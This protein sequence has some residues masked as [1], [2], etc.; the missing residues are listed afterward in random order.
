MRQ[1]KTWLIHSATRY[2][3]RCV[4]FLTGLCVLVIEVVA[5]RI[6]SPHFGNTIYSV[7]SVISVILTALALGYSYGGRL[8]D[9]HPS[10]GL[11]YRVILSSGIAVLASYLISFV[12]LPLLASLLSFSLGPL[13]SSTLLFLLPAFL[14]GILSPFAVALE[15]KRT[16]NEGVGEASGNVFFYSTLGSILG[17][18]LAGFVLIPHFGIQYIMAGTGMVLVLLGLLGA[19]CYRAMSPLSVTAVLLI[20]LILFAALYLVGEKPFSDQIVHAEES[21]YSHIAILDTSYKDRPVRLNMLDK[22]YSGAMF[23]D[24]TDPD[25]HVF[26]YTPYYKIYTLFNDAP[27]RAL[28]IGGAASYTVP[29]ALL[30]RESEIVVDVAEIDPRLT[31]LAHEY[32]R[33]PESPRL[34]SHA[35]DAR[36]FLRTTSARYDTIFGDAFSSF[37]GMPSHLATHEFFMLVRERLTPNG[38]FVMNVIGDLE[39]RER[40]LAYALM[41]TFRE[42]FPDGAFFATEDP[43]SLE[44]QNIIFVG[45]REPTVPLKESYVQSSKSPDPLIASLAWRGIPVPPTFLEKYPILTDNYAPVEYLVAPSFLKQ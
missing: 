11:F 6:L 8:A 31:E 19:V 15:K 29:K 23:L 30:A 39:P 7:S 38:V 32:F 44:T 4:V 20:S 12:A 14:L 41:R 5:T 21:V 2:E 17:G 27:R 1:I 22:G 40:N 28:V 18:I 34:I 42:V 10:L 3:L 45:V 13:V 25:D 43:R 35:S 9:R 26:D 37:Y 24:S 36:A 16:P 33:V